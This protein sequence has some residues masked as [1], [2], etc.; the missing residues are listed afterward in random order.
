MRLELTDYQD[1]AVADVASAIDEGVE[2]FESHEKLTAISLSAPTGAGKTVIAT[3]VIERLWFGDQVAE[4]RP[5]VT[6]LWVTDDPNLNQQTRRKMLVTS[7]LIQPST[8]EVVGTSLDQ[9][10]LDSGKVY[11]VHIQQLGKGATRYNE[12]GDG[13]QYGL[14]TII[15]NTIA[16]RGRDFL[17]VIDEA[18]KGTRRANGGTI[19]AQLTDGAGG[20]FPAAPIVLGISATPKRFNEAITDT[21]QR[22][23]EPVGVSPE[24]VRESGLL[25]DKI[26]IKH[27]T[28]SQPGDFTLLEL[29]VQDLKQID[30][31]W[32]HY[33]TSQHEP[34]VRPALVLQVRPAIGDARSRRHSRHARVHLECDEWQSDRALA[35]GP[36]HAQLGNPQRQVHSATGHPG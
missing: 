20:K 21:G 16:D 24:A 26:L 11:F 31:L 36:R 28:E 6:V 18:H 35:A 19:T 17:L 10:T 8:V 23:L 4:P 33:S 27:P 2:R 30:A 15:G 13:R 32:T 9:R 14:W 3:A 22:T 1:L 25:K 12:V 7:E 34:P 29:A 5:D